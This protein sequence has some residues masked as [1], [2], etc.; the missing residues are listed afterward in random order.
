M[1]FASDFIL[2]SFFCGCAAAMS[3]YLRGTFVFFGAAFATEVTYVGI[4]LYSDIAMCRC[5]YGWCVQRD[6]VH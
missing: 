6:S 2:S 5:V 4:S 1:L 3:R